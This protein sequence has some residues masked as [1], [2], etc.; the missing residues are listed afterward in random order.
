MV[1]VP[2]NQLT[3][4]II[5]TLFC[6]VWNNKIGISVIYDEPHFCLYKRASLRDENETLAVVSGETLA[7]TT[8]GL[9]TSDK[10][11]L[12]MN[13]SIRERTFQ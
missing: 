6:L 1:Q 4:V 5:F 7:F 9:L 8:N 11:C 2:K 12:A 10:G 3:R 13:D